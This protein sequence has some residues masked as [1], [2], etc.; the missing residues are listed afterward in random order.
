MLLQRKTLLDDLQ[1]QG[2]TFNEDLF[3]AF[4]CLKTVEFSE[5]FKRYIEDKKS[6]WEEGANMTA[7]ELCKAAQTKF[8][9]LLEAGKWRFTTTITPIVT[10]PKE[11]KDKKDTKF[12]ALAAAVK[13]LVKNMSKSTTLN[14]SDSQKSK[15]KFE[16]PASGNG[17]EKEV[18]SKIYWWCDGGASKNHKPM[19]CRHKPAECKKQNHSSTSD[20]KPVP[21]PPSNENKGE[22]KLKINNNLATALAALDKVLQSSTNSDEEDEQDFS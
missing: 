13:E 12:I 11:P 15:W 8:K 5:S 18:N 16:A 7:P 14:N 9:H 21:K 1:A 3:W 10:E 6:E 17:T 22:P 20:A 2:E 4:K 19:Y